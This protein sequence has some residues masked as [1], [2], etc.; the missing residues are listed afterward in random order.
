MVNYCSLCRVESPFKFLSLKRQ[1]L[2]NKYPKHD[3]FEGEKFFPLEAFFCDSCKNV[4]L[5]EI[6]S[7]EL[8]F[9][10]YFYLS[11]VNG[12]LV[13]HFNALADKLSGSNFVVDVGSNDGILLK[14]LKARHV[15]ALGIEPSI[16]VSKIANDAGLETICSFFDENLARQV[17]EEYGPADVIVASSVF[18]HLEDPAKFIEA[19]K[20]LL[21]PEGSIIIEVEYISN[22]I[23]QGQFER[24]YL[25]RIFYYSI[26]SL[27]SLC[28][29]F[30]MVISSIEEI[31]Q[32]GGSI[33]VILRHASEAQETTKLEQF[34]SAELEVLNCEY[35]AGFG[36]RCNDMTH[37]LKA[38]LM[39]WKD[40]GVKVAGYG[41]PARLS[42]ITNFG[43]IGPDLIPFTVDDSL[44][45]QGRFS[46]GMHIPI[47]SQKILQDFNPDIV[48]VF[49]YEYID[50]ILKKT[51]NRFEY[52]MPI[53]L[54][55]LT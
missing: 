3:Q 4:Q 25:D 18:T 29:R 50:D 12:G 6:V 9:E 27:K 2:A 19:A 15:K 11:S 53:P 33:Q 24:F 44:L 21:T 43:G 31:N 51:G 38:A 47:V 20:I 42:T 26:S 23:K 52:F 7:R 14:P 5:G 8:M 46:P 41:A 28:A 34:V 10:D 54:Q 30:D 36:R 22:I 48:I 49:A 55:K 39:D 32:H 35:L 37:T 1:P 40:K 13:R 45:K 17:M 16:N